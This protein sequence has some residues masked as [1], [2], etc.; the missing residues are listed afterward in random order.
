MKQGS[1]QIVQ[2]QLSV[3]EIPYPVEDISEDFVSLNGP[4]KPDNNVSIVSFA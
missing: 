2:V 4:H 3:E 1:I